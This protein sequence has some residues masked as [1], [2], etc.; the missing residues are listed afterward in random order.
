MKLK[1]TFQKLL[2]L[3][4]CLLDMQHQTQYNSTSDLGFRKGHMA[5]MPPA[6]HCA[7][8]SGQVKAIQSILKYPIYDPMI[9]YGDCGTALHLLL[10]RESS[11]DYLEEFRMTS[12]FHVL[13]N[14]YWYKCIKNDFNKLQDDENKVRPFSANEM[15][16][17]NLLLQGGIDIW[18]PHHKTKELPS[19]GP[20]ADDEARKWWYEKVIKE[21]V[22]LKTSISDAANAT[23][24]VA[25]LVATASFIGPL[26]PPLG[27]S[28]DGGYVDTS[29][30]SIQVYLVFNSLSFFFS[31][32][33]ILM[34]VLPAIPMPKESLYDELLRSQRCLKGAA[35]MLLV[36]IICILVSFSS[37]SMVVVSSRWHD[38]RLVVGCIVVGGSVCI[39]VL[40]IYII[41]LLRM[42]FHK[43]TRFRRWFA[44]HMYF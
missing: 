11:K 8:L 40:G 14:S 30:S 36:S 22:T 12:L 44:K 9:Q 37:A 27:L 32:G 7:A 19:P 20:T 18:T 24:V 16:C 1:I 28:G 5:D 15:N 31:I 2:L 25:A 41:R 6:V 39:V 35:L 33:S 38:K 43:N 3:T 21:V 42:L 34:A 23:S 26:Q 29:R 10:Q 17:I 13:P 4:M